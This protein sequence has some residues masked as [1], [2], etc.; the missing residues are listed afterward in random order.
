MKVRIKVKIHIIRKGSHT[1]WS[2]WSQGIDQVIL[3]MYLVMQCIHH[4]ITSSLQVE[5]HVLRG[6]LGLGTRNLCL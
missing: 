5:K 3:N 4:E 1:L 6:T 2:R